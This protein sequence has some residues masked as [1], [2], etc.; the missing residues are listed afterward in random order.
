[1]N[2]DLKITAQTLNRYINYQQQKVD[3]LASKIKIKSKY[4][5]GAFWLTNLYNLELKHMYEKGILNSLT[6]CKEYLY[7]VREFNTYISKQPEINFK[8]EKT[9]EVTKYDSLVDWL[10]AMY[11][12]GVLKEGSQIQLD[13]TANIIDPEEILEDFYNKV[14]ES[15]SGSI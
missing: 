3:K 5:I 9:G 1:M 4:K 12:N 10:D 13:F 7:M 11:V 6:I 14:T 2:G 8:D 15:S